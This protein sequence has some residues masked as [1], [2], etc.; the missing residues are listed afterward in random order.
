MLVRSASKGV[1][2]L[3]RLWARRN[4]SLGFRFAPLALIGSFEDEELE[5]EANILAVAEFNSTIINYV[6]RQVYAS[7]RCFPYLRR[8]KNPLGR[9]QDLVSDGLFVRPRPDR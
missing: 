1:A 5:L 9:G 6:E 8:A 2:P 7:D 3:P 4:W